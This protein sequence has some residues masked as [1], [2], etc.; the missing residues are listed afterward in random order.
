MLI[1]SE[2]KG[3]TET[4]GDTLPFCLPI[5]WY[6]FV[7]LTG[8]YSSAQRHRDKFSRLS[9]A[10]VEYRLPRNLNDVLSSIKFFIESELNDRNW[11]KY[12]EDFEAFAYLVPILFENANFKPEKTE[13]ALSNILKQ[14]KVTLGANMPNKLISFYDKLP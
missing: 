12:S 9:I 10:F 4:F 2:D 13:A 14:Y 8:F 3:F 5:S 7:R 1:L 6:P 11:L